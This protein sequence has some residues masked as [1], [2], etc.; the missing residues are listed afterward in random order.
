MPSKSNTVD[1]IQRKATDLDDDAQLLTEQ[2]MVY[3]RDGDGVFR[4]K[5]RELLQEQ[6]QGPQEE[7]G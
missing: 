5:L 4:R 2:T 7:S 3:L 1:V 6:A